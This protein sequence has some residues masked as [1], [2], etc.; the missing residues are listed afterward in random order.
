MHR[1]RYTIGGLGIVI[2][3]FGFGFAALKGDQL[4]FSGLFTL[5]MAG[6]LVAVLGAMFGRGPDRAFCAGAFLGGS[7]YLM[8]VYI[9]DTNHLLLTDKLLRAAADWP[10]FRVPS[11][12][13]P[14]A[15]AAARASYQVLFDERMVNWRGVEYR[16]AF[17]GV[18]HLMFSWLWAS[19]GGLVARAFASRDRAGPSV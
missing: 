8:L 7:F 2:A 4:W 15:S 10:Q 12:P 9:G 3:A 13:G 18:G 14:S 16:T 19:G 1:P 6:L 11:P 17:E 5:T